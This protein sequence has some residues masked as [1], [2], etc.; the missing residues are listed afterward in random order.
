ME[1]CANCNS[2]FKE[3]SDKRGSFRFSVEKKLPNSDIT[4]RDALC[5]ATG[6]P[7][8]PASKRKGRF[9]CPSCWWTLNGMVKYKK[10]MDEFWGKSVP[11]S[12]VGA[13]RKAPDIPD[14]ASAAKR[15]LFTS[16]PKV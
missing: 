7:F 8:T 14:M 5:S 6:A 2:E 11:T 3:R 9:L 16:T 15:P 12:Y 4:A 1:L 13:K 10:S